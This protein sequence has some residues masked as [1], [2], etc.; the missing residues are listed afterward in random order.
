MGNINVLVQKLDDDHVEFLENEGEAL[1]QC[2]IKI[3]R[4]NPNRNLPSAFI[5]DLRDRFFNYWQKDHTTIIKDFS[6]LH[7]LP[8]PIRTDVREINYI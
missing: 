7:Q 8:I 3:D 4:A 5:K 1:D 2:L 6:F